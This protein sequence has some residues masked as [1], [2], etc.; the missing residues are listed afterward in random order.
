MGISHGEPERW[1]PGGHR[2]ASEL[3][4]RTSELSAIGLAVDAAAAGAGRVV[5]V[6]GRA[7]IGK[8][9]LLRAGRAVAAEQGL[10]VLAARSAELERAFGF[11][12]VRQLLDQHVASVGVESLAGSAAA[13]AAPAFDPT[14]AAAAPGFG[15]PVLPVLHGLFWLAMDLAGERP[16]ALVVDD[17]HWADAASLRFLA[18]LA[19][20]IEG[21]PLLLLIATRPPETGAEPAV[22]TGLASDPETIVLRPGALETD[23]VR[24]LIGARFE[25]PAEDAFVAA[26]QRATG[27]NP[28]LVVELAAALRTEQVPPTAAGAERVAGLGPREIVHRLLRRLAGLPAGAHELAHAV[29]VLGDRA[30]ASDAAGL[31]GLDPGAVASVADSLITAGVLAPTSD[32]QFAHPVIRQAV[33][34]AIATSAR[35]ELHAQAARLLADRAAASE[36]VAAHLLAGPARGYPGAVGALRAAAREAA[37]RGA[38]D[39]AAT[40][41][42]RALAEPP[43]R[44]LLGELLAELGTVE[45][46]AGDTAAAADL[47]A[48]LAQLDD[49]RRSAAVALEL[50]RLAFLSADLDGA[51]DVLT[52]AL[53]PLGDADRELRLRLQAQITMTDND[54]IVRAPRR[55]DPA[56]LRGETPG[57]RALLATLAFSQ[58]MEARPATEAWSTAERALAG[59]QLF[60]DA[61]GGSPGSIAAI[62][63]LVCCD[64]DSEVRPALRTAIAEARRCGDVTFYA[65]ACAA[66]SVAAYRAGDLREAVSDGTEALALSVAHDIGWLRLL[67]LGF[68]VYALVERD[69][70]DVAERALA[71]HATTG[72]PPANHSDIT[73]LAARSRVQAARGDLDEALAGLLE[74]GRWLEAAGVDNPALTPW[75]SFAAEVLLRQGRKEEAAR[76]ADAELA[77]ARVV[78][79]PY[80]LG[81][82]LRASGLA[83]PGPAGLELLGA[84][85][86]TLAGSPCRL[87]HAR[88]LVDL[89]DRLHRAGQRVAARERLYTGLDVAAGCGARALDARARDLLRRA[90]ARPRRAARSGVDSLTPSERRVARM[91]ATGMTNREIAQALFVTAKTVE[92]H[93]GHAYPKLGVR[94]RGELAAALGED[95]AGAA[96]LAPAT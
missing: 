55:V 86:T 25:Q 61:G 65:F 22:L 2:P 13:A 15:D 40:Y 11:G 33:Y 49:P 30:H 56:T 54:R 9:S 18:Y 83:T 77:I 80:A 32:L 76:L 19:G 59:G 23:A 66:R 34:E 10:R 7:G 73:V 8:T 51:H 96:P 27:G 28:L 3:L 79:S 90:G 91:A 60:R 4:Q 95:V 82:A 39:T 44:E 43:P 64:R 38:P 14:S 57:E 93:L 74:A 5:L 12:V 92:M 87:E 48:A 84:A 53:A 62:G 26:V 94:G 35:A 88:A 21:S 42:R 50:G 29:A 75:R 67:A 70:L 81:N 47:N 37:D 24:A 68:L 6:E 41:L 36:E 31:A 17:A 78:G 20:R 89:G 1:R 46:R 63:A 71:D 45:A 69:E 58:L 72:T 16:L 52:R 85:V